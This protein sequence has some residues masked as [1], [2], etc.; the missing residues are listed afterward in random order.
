LLESNEKIQSL[1][2]KEKEDEQ[3]KEQDNPEGTLR[4]KRDTFLSSRSFFPTLPV[5][6]TSKMKQSEFCWL[7]GLVKGTVFGIFHPPQ[8]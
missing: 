2:K 7:N 5:L 6:Y 4:I 3:K 1:E 8:F